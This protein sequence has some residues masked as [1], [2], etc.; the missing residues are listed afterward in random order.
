VLATFAEPAR[1]VEAAAAIIGA[2]HDLGLDVR[3][4]IH[5]GEVGTIDGKL[6]GTDVWARPWRGNPK[7]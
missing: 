6:C 2:V 5:T 4:G 1:A 7:V 3:A